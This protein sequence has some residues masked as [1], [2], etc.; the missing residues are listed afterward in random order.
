MKANRKEY[1]PVRIRL[2]GARK[3]ALWIGLMSW[4]LCPVNADETDVGALLAE[5]DIRGDYA[6]R[7]LHSFAECAQSGIPTESLYIRLR[8]GLIKQ[9]GPD[10][11]ADALERRY[12]TLARAQTLLS[13]ATGRFRRQPHSA[14]ILEILANALESGVPAAA[15]EGLF[16]SGRRARLHRLSAV[17][18]A[19]EM[20]HLAGVEASDVRWFMHEA[21]DRDSRRAEV[22]RAARAWIRLHREGYD[23]MDIRER[24]W[25]VNTPTATRIE[26]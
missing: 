7:I 25:D 19:G 12:E 10:L 14:E 22:L 8:E 2:R 24:I 26:E 4:A 16:P 18:E 11:L 1:Q 20:L 6:E 3:L 9:A 23:N 13:S 5:Y 17:I 21:R 15:F